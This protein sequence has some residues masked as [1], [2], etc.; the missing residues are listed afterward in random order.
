MQV[1]TDER[2]V[3]GGEKREKER[4]ADVV[5]ALLVIVA[6]MDEQTLARHRRC[7]WKR[8]S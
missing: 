7:V 1:P 8:I 2:D 6:I 4:E 3:G 5:D